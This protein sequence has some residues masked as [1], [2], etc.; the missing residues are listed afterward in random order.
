MLLG[1]SFGAMERAKV[2]STIRLVCV[3][4]DASDSL[5]TGKTVTLRVQRQSDGYFLK[6]DGTWAAAPGTEYTFSET[7]AT[8][9]P[10]TYH[11]AWTLPATLDSYIIR[12]D[13]GTS[14]TPVP[15]Y[16]FGR[17]LAVK[18]DESDMHKAKAMLVNRKEQA[19]ATGVVTIYDDDG[20]TAL[21]NLTPDQDTPAN[22]T[23]RIIE[24]DG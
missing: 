10:G 5:L 7:D 11:Y 9:M 15:R 6:N 3:L 8:N 24:S 19:I 17:L 18:L 2:S 1:A 4:R 14:G 13:C 12:A 16:L 21:F 23:S 20:V 22:P